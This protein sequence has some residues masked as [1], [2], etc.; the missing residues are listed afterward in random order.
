MGGGGGGG[1]VEPITGCTRRDCLYNLRGGLYTLRVGWLI[2]YPVSSSDKLG[3]GASY[4]LLSSQ[5][6]EVLRRCLLMHIGIRGVDWLVVWV[7]EKE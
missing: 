2:L 7:F 4:N 3:K 1:G 5:L 6:R